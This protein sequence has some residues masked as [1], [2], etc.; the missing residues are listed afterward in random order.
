LAVSLLEPE[1]RDSLFAWGFFPEALQ[2][3]EYIEAYIGAPMGEWMLSHNPRL[4]AEFDAKLRAEA[5]FSSDRRARLH[6]F[7]ERSPFYDE[8]YRLYPVGLES[9]EGSRPGESPPGKPHA[10][11][12]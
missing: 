1:C 3:S 11:V 6:W 7:Y 9:A 5:G 8:R 2:E 10:E 12:P 4:K